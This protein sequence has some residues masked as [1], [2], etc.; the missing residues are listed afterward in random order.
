MNHLLQDC[1]RSVWLRAWR[2]AQVKAGDIM[3]QQKGH[4]FAGFPSSLHH[5]DGARFLN[6]AQPQAYTAGRS[7]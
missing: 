4:A 2:D 6:H 1:V 7:N 5:V 3:I